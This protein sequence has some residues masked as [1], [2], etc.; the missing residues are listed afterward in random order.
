LVAIPSSGSNYVSVLA[1]AKVNAAAT[2]E[3]TPTP[4]A[5]K[6]PPVVPMAKK[7]SFTASN[8]NN[9]A[10]YDNGGYEHTEF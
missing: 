9:M 5:G 1:A 6:R 8:R 7:V 4:K 10:L 2:P 3:G